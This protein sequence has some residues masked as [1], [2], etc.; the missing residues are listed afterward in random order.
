MSRDCVALLSTLPYSTLAATQDE[1]GDEPELDG[2]GHL[3]VPVHLGTKV[4]VAGWQLWSRFVL[5]CWCL[6]V[7]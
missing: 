4:W 6:L 1:N 2:N 7:F 5:P 3:Q